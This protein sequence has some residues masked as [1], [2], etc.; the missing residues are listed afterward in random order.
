MFHQE[1]SIYRAKGHRRMRPCSQKQQWNPPYQPT[2]TTLHN[3]PCQGL[4]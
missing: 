2:Y 4:P 1:I 3:T